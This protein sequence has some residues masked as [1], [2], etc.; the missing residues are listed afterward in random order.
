MF[1]HQS[2]AYIYALIYYLVYYI[3]AQSIPFKIFLTLDHFFAYMLKSKYRVLFMTFP[4]FS[5]ILFTLCFIFHSKAHASDIATMAVNFPF[6]QGEVIGS[7]KHPVVL[8]WDTTIIVDSREVGVS[9]PTRG[10]QRGFRVFLRP[11]TGKV[12][13]LETSVGFV[14]AS[15][16]Q[17]EAF[18]NLDVLYIEESHRRKGFAK[19]S[20]TLF[21]LAL[22]SKESEFKEYI[23]INLESTTDAMMA[24]MANQAKWTPVFGMEDTFMRAF[25]GRELPNLLVHG[26]MRDIFA[27]PPNSGDRMLESLGRS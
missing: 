17:E 8:Q 26:P 6:E 24:L 22:N 21:C 1:S 27:Y 25:K 14:T 9:A 18:I 4:K 10:P 2:I 20:L 7:P 11:E 15:I 23:G 13:D 5:K 16:N 19:S 12:A 3:G